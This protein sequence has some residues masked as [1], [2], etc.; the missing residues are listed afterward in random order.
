MLQYS[1]IQFS[2]LYYV[3]ILIRCCGLKGKCYYNEIS[4]HVTF[5]L[6]S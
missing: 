4:T 3:Y 6:R 1:S 2:N 5:T